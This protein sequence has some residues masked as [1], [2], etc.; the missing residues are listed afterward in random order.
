MEIKVSSTTWVIE[1]DYV[2][3]E[4]PARILQGIFFS[5]GRPRYIN[6]GTIGSIIGHEINHGFDDEVHSSR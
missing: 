6:Y 3:T 2:P 1:I 5:T 4:F